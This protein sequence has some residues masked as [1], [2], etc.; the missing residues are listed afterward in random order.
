MNPDAMGCSTN[1][2]KTKKSKLSP[3]KIIPDGRE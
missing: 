1:V 3:R 2:I